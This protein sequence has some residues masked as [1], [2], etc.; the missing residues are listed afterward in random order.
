[1]TQEKLGRIVTAV[2]VAA[3]T[4]FVILLSVLI[5]Q[6]ITIAVYDKRIDEINEE[7][8]ALEQDIAQD[9]EDLKHYSSNLGKFWLAIE[10][11]FV[12]GNK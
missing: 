12:E 5:Y 4:L 11:G 9:E 8:A 1:M 6:W 2:V 7:I 10:K 3:T